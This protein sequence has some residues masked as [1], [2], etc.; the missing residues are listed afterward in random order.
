[1][2]RPVV[3]PERPRPS[4]VH[5]LGH[6]PHRRR[7]RDHIQSRIAPSSRVRCGRPFIHRHGRRVP[8]HAR[9]YVV[10]D[11]RKR[12]S[13]CR[14]VAVGRCDGDGLSL[15]RSVVCP[16]GPTP[17]SA[18][19]RDRAD[20]RC[21]RDSIDSRIAECPGVRRDRAFVDRYGRVVRGDARR[22]VVD[23][24]RRC[25]VGEAAVFVENSAANNATRR[26]VGKEAGRDRRARGSSRSGIRSVTDFKGAV[27]VEVIRVVEA[28][29]RI[30]A[31][32]VRLSREADAPRRAFIDRA[33]VGQRRRRS[34]VVDDQVKRR[35]GR[36]TFRVGGRDRDRLS[37]PRPVIR[38]E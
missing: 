20:R 34:H 10:D 19:G 30:D 14:T 23:R 17:S 9:S 37:L 36:C 29:R 8:C 38:C 21:D 25:V 15:I 12:R 13:R 27:I 33:A 6:R 28:R 7:Q 1:M 32:S 22:D 4:P 5:V 16:E 35:V 24:D 26:P 2:I 3:C 11:E 31:R 18:A